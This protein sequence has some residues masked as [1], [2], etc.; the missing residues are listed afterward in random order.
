MFYNGDLINVLVDPTVVLLVALLILIEALFIR[1]EPEHSCRPVPEFVGQGRFLDLTELLECLCN[2]HAVRLAVGGVICIL[3]GPLAGRQL[4]T[5]DVKSNLFYICLS[6]LPPVS[7]TAATRPSVLTGKDLIAWALHREVD[8][9][10]ISYTLQFLQVS[11]ILVFSNSNK[12]HACRLLSGAKK[13]PLWSC[14]P[15]HSWQQPW[16]VF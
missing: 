10:F 8:P 4:V 3:R 1:K 16:V 6:S 13:R 7:L 15:I 2:M 14:A 5:T 11:M 12:N 9:Y